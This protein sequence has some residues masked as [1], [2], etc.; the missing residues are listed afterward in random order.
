ML[1]GQREEGRREAET[2]GGWWWWGGLLTRHPSAPDHPQLTHTQNPPHTSAFTHSRR[3]RCSHARGQ[4]RLP[5]PAG[6]WGQ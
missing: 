6:R 2:R 4:A 5:S 1:V 3:E